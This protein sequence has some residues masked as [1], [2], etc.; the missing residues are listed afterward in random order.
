LI[1]DRTFT[2]EERLEIASLLSN[3][4]T[5]FKTFWNVGKPIFTK[6]IKT[7]AVGFDSFGNTLYMIINPDFW[8]SL[9]SVNKAFII[10]HECLHIILKHG[11]RGMA[12]KNQDAVNI[13]MDIVINEMLVFSFGFNKLWQPDIAYA[14]DV[15]IVNGSPK[16]IELNSFSSSGF[17]ACDISKIIHAIDR[18]AIMEYNGDISIGDI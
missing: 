16:I 2:Y 3:H 6:S 9:N 13:A 1:I 4:H 12:F 17:Y 18:V 8:D 7:A 10:A 5:I 14:C 15:G 11:Q